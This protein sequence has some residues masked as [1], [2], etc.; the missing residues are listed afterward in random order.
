MSVF[1]FSLRPEFPMLGSGK[2]QC[3]LQ[4]FMGRRHHVCEAWIV[5][6]CCGTPRQGHGGTISS[7]ESVVV[8]FL[9]PHLLAS[10]RTV[11][12]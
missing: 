12:C 9:I 8:L 2:P 3:H 10:P 7:A 6:E 5:S 11:F 1:G 4:G